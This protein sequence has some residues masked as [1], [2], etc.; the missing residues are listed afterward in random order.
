MPGRNERSCQIRMSTSLWNLVGEIVQELGLKDARGGHSEVIRE[1][2]AAAAAV[3]IHSPYVC[4]SAR[5]TV[6][7]NR[8]GSVFT[9]QVHVLRLNTPRDK[10]PC[11]INMKPEKKEYYHRKFRDRGI[12]SEDQW[13]LDQ[14]LVNYFAMWSGRKNS[15]ELSEFVATPLSDY[16]DNL[17]TTY[18]SADLAVNAVG[19]RS[20]TREITIGLRDYVQW[21]EPYADGYDRIAIPIDVPT[22][23]LEICVVVDRDLF[24]GLEREEIGRLTL[25]FRTRESARFEGKEVVA[26]SKNGIEEQYGRSAA[27]DDGTDE[28][29]KRVRR[30][31][32][33]VAKILDGCPMA[34]RADR[35]TIVSS[36]ALPQDFLFYWLKWPS[37][38]LGVEPCVCWEKPNMR[39]SE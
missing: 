17:G 21:K 22:D 29:L 8:E 4:R 38:H 36:L 11:F 15:D 3:R 19:G 14:W 6:F 2:V 10:V 39:P 33:R 5:H 16:V 7:V 13:F 24:Y 37:P 35:A 26:Y 31:R 20:F 34:G 9:R 12:S 30:L 27:N 28:M 23:D 1:M 32:Q 18:K 25:E